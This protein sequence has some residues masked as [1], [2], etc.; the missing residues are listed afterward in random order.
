MVYIYQIE[1]EQRLKCVQQGNP[2]L[3]YIRNLRWVYGEIVPDY[4]LGQTTCALYL[5]S[6]FEFPD[7]DVQILLCVQQFNIMA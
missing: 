7:Q 3:K 6:Q 4:I 2:V 5:R 1:A